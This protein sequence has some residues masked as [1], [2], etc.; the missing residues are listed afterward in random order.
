ME[1]GKPFLGVQFDCCRV[2]QRIYLNKEGTAYC[3][4]CPRCGKPIKFIVGKGGTSARF[5]IAK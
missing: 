3:G 5:F 1:K 4:R 2:Y